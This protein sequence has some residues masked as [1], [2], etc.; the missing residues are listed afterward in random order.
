MDPLPLEIS[1]LQVRDLLKN[2]PLAGSGVTLIDVREPGEHAICHI[3]GARLIPMQT[4]PAHLQELEGDERT[5]VVFCHHGMRSLSVVDWLRRQGLETA[6]AW[7]AASTA[8]V[9]RSIRRYRVIKPVDLLSESAPAATLNR[10]VRI[11][12]SPVLNR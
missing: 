7:L 6:R 9:R 11:A 4:I 5:L 3:E 1:P 8:G 12:S 2:D 10:K